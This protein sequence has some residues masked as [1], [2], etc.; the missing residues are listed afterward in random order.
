MKPFTLDDAAVTIEAP[1][2]KIKIPSL[3]ELDD[4]VLP[5]FAQVERGMLPAPP[6]P[7]SSLE[8]SGQLT[9]IVDIALH[10]TRIMISRAW[11]ELTEKEAAIKTS[12][13]QTVYSTQVKVDDTRLR[14]RQV[15]VLPKLLARIAE[16]EKRLTMKTVEGTQLPSA[17][18]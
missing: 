5:V 12:L 14:A 18:S 9:E 15:D 13:I 2:A 17:L 1:P 7:V 10:E 3:D 8:A 11:D 6:A 4:A 16:A